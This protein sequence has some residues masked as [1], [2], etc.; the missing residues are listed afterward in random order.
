MTT[1][2]APLG[3]R[4][5]L[6]GIEV[7]AISAQVT[8]QQDRPAT[9]AIQVIPT[10]MA[11]NLL[12]RTLVHLFYLDPDELPDAYEEE[13]ITGIG[14]PRTENN[15]NRISAKDV[16]YKLLFCGEVI[17]FNYG[18]TPATRQLILQCMDLSSYWDTCYQWFADYSVG[19]DGLTDRSHQFVGAGASMFNSVA[20]GHQWVIG[21]LL[22]SK[23]KNKAYQNAGGL[24]GGLIHLLEAIGGVR[25]SKGDPGF[26]GVN[27]FFTIAELRYNLLSMIG[28]VESDETS[29]KMFANKAFR[30]WLRNGMTSL[31]SLL[32]FRDIVNHVNRHIYHNI[33]PNPCSRFVAEG[34]E[35]QEKQFTTYSSIF[36]DDDNI[37][38][39][40]V[41][42][43]KQLGRNVAISKMFF[44]DVFEEPRGT[45]DKLI[46]KWGIPFWIERGQPAEGIVKT[47]S[48]SFLRGRRSIAALDNV[49]GF[50]ETSASQLKTDDKSDVLSKLTDIRSRLATLLR[51]SKQYNVTGR[52]DVAD[53]QDE[54][55]KHLDELN[56]MLD[57]LGDLLG[58]K[59]K[60]RKGN[61]T[62]TLRTGAHLYSQLILPELFFASPPRCNVLFPDQ[63]Y[64]FS[65]S[66]NFMREVTRLSCRGGLGMI[67]GGRRGAKLLGSHYFAPD[68]VDAKGKH[69]YSTW[70]KGARILMPHEVHS[71]IIPKFEWVSDAHRWGSKAA[72]D[73]NKSDAFHQSGKVGYVQRLANYQLYIHRWSSRSMSVT[74]VFNPNL[75]IGLPALVMDRAMPAPAV[76]KMINSRLGRR[77]MPTQY[78]G[79]LT[80]LTHQVHQGGGQSSMQL[81]K[82]RTHRA[83]DDEFMGV[84][85]RE[86]EQLKEVTFTRVIGPRELIRS[87]DYGSIPK[88][89]E[90]NVGAFG[91]KYYVKDLELMKS[92][93]RQFID[94]ENGKIEGKRYF[95][96]SAVLKKIV[97]TGSILLSPAEARKLEIKGALD[98]KWCFSGRTEESVEDVGTNPDGSPITETV[99]RSI[100]GLALPAKMTLTFSKMVGTGKYDRVNRTVEEAIRP[101]WYSPLWGNERIGKEAYQQLLGVDAITDNISVASDQVDEVIDKAAKAEATATMSKID[102][103]TGDD[104]FE[105]GELSESDDSGVSMG[106]NV[107]PGSIEEAVDSIS[108]LYGLIKSRGGDVHSFISQYTKRPIANMQEILGSPELRIK[109]DG[110]I[111]TTSPGTENVVEGF[112]SR[113]F[114]DYNTDVTYPD[115]GGKTQTKAGKLALHGLFEGVASGT[116]VKRESAIDR[117]E[118][119]FALRP[120][121][122]PRGRARS[123]VRAYID[124][125]NISRGL[126][127]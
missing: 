27:D 21:R 4:L 14:E 68:I 51:S 44:D 127:G 83:L 65:F 25:Y 36:S 57:I 42:E 20:G 122:D 50:A 15:R 110:N 107:L 32:S 67:A 46:K 85:T 86:V 93:L 87:A 81:T 88:A 117:G 17:G 34:S 97:Q 91:V 72:K 104:L 59:K 48:D 96:N 45:P 119:K 47:P 84:L 69:L 18:K 75:V 103:D 112:H 37:G 53:I 9:A 55:G 80:A 115:S 56:A 13:R 12:P 82:C 6:E 76:V 124:E 26:N 54:A 28:A 114:G 60:A 63:Y 77:W 5:F 22:N 7:P 39:T 100:E 2:V 121:L 1:K 61:K 64:Q 8:I 116:E 41:D 106:L 95:N 105:H 92:I 40:L 113:A 89:G 30:A 35:D 123:R 108:I 70:D 49:L 98:Q 125:L 90:I 58:M 62:V 74:G 38:P 29:Q 43:L 10:D 111:D 102:P 73:T 99:T 33:Y 16:Q 71:G 109:D 31:G 3:L 11:M 79:K 78:L 126:L 19:G 118:G 24:L 94:K 101:G 66:R 120:E 23:P 52:T